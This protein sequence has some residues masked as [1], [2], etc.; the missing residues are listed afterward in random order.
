[1]HYTYEPEEGVFHSMEFCSAQG[2]RSLYQFPASKKY[3]TQNLAKLAV[4]KLAIKEHER[5]VG[6]IY[7][8]R[9]GRPDVVYDV[10]FK[11][12]DCE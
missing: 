3:H 12:A 6:I 4:G 10:A 11:I 9:K 8:T 2:S 5:F 1:M 7:N